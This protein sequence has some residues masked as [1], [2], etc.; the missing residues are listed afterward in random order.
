MEGVH[1]VAV[2]TVECPSREHMPTA[3]RLPANDTIAAGAKWWAAGSM[4]SCSCSKG[5]VLTGCACMWLPSLT[6]PGSC[7]PSTAHALCPAPHFSCAL[8]PVPPSKLAEPSFMYVTRAGSTLQGTTVCV[9]E[10]I[11]VPTFMEGV[12]VQ[13]QEGSCRWVH[14]LTAS[15][16][17]LY[18]C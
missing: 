3:K 18:A 7:R 16:A 4:C 9:A 2:M 10:Q 12:V 17:A 6:P 11:V 14:C 1:A 13:F 15:T 5:G 8:S